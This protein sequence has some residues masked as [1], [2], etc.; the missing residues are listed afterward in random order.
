MASNAAIVSYHIS[1]D[2]S[3]VETFVNKY[4]CIH[5]E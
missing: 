2:E 5:S 3:L 4:D 1:I